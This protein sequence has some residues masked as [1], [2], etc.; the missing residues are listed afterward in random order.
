MQL[1]QQLLNKLPDGG[2]QHMRV[3]LAFAT[4]RDGLLLS[5]R[6]CALDAKT[7]QDLLNYVTKTQYVNCTLTPNLDPFAIRTWIS[8]LQCISHLVSPPSI[9]GALDS[10]LFSR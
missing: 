7:R 9:I 10:T 8:D 4:Q 2:C 1:M 5:G 3:S 6:R